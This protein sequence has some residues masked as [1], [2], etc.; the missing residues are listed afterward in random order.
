MYQHQSKLSLLDLPSELLI[1]IFEFASESLPTNNRYQLLTTLSLTHR[2]FLWPAQSV[3]FGTARLRKQKVAHKWLL[4]TQFGSGNKY[5]TWDIE[6]HG[7]QSGREGVSAS[8][9][10]KVL[11]RAFGVRRLE[12]ADFGRLSAK[13]LEKEGLKTLTNLHLLTGFPDTSP[14]IIS[15]Q[16]PF[17]LQQLHLYNSPYPSSLLSVL[18][19]KSSRSLQTLTLSLPH[20]APA[21]PGLIASFPLIA[22]TL[23]HLIL[24]HR[25][26]PSLLALL[27]QC[28]SLE[29]LSCNC[30]VDINSVI[31]ALAGCTTL[32]TLKMELDWDLEEVLEGFQKRLTEFAGVTLMGLR[33]LYLKVTL[34]GKGV[35]A[36]VEELVTVCEGRGIRVILEREAKIST[37]KGA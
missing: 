4:A 8:T 36:R 17:H 27:S 22:P 30:S 10:G 14:T 35:E 18:F 21:Y 15:L 37:G 3:L 16:L 13:V 32:K 34:E 20:F 31:D 9:A 33:T 24:V 1:P 6:L 11:D 29:T 26:S 5:P 25:P 7:I 19:R 23:L 12:L 28:S 2:S